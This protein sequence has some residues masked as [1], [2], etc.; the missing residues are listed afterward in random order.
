MFEQI[1][2]NVKNKTPL[3]H[4]ITNY[5]TVND[6]ANAILACGGS[7]IMADD[8]NEVED[9]TSICNSLVIN[10]GTLNKNT[11]EAMELAGKKANEIGHPVILDPV[12]VGASALRNQCVSR[13]LKSVKFSVIRG[14][15]SEI[16][17]VY[18]GSGSTSGVD[19]NQADIVTKDNIDTT[20]EIAKEL[21]KTTGAVIAISGEYD[22]ITD[23]KK[24][25]IIKNGHPVM[26]KITGSGCMSTSVIGAFV[27][28]NYEA[29]LDSTAAAVAC[30]GLSGE[31]ACEKIVKKD[32]GL[33]SLRTYMI[34]YIGKMDEKMLNR[35][36]KIEIK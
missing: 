3:V 5:V 34:D 9:I 28:A 26:T 18:K 2:T 31:L 11:I 14:N 27:G 6:C 25:Y 7:P 15:I 33:S 29:I 17:S 22:I 23:G 10:I 36:I 13:L 16:K 12:G 1:I 35:G 30:M 4:A 20:I 32:E 21:S 24:A 19:A 8:A